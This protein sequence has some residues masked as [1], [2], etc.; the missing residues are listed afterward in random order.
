M[1]SKRL[2]LLEAQ[3][4]QKKPSTERR[5]EAPQ[6][7]RLSTAKS[8]AG[9]VNNGRK[10][11]EVV[12]DAVDEGLDGRR[13]NEIVTDAVDERPPSTA[14]LEKLRSSTTKAFA[15]IENDNWANEIVNIAV[16]ARINA[17]ALKKQTSSAKKLR[18][19]VGNVRRAKG[20]VAD[21][22]D[23]TLD[24]V[25]LEKQTPPAT[26]SRSAFVNDRRAEEVVTDAV[27]EGLNHGSAK[28]IGTDAVDE[29]F[30]TVA[31]ERSSATK[32]RIPF[33]NV[34][35]ANEIMTDTVNERVNVVALGEQR[36]SATKPFSASVIGSRRAKEI[37]TDAVVGERLNAVA[38]VKQRSLTIKPRITFVIRQKAKDIVT[39]TVDARLNPDALEKQMSSTTRP[40]SAFADRNKASEIV[41]DPEDERLDAVA[42]MLDARS[43]DGDED[44]DT[45]DTR[46]GIRDEDAD[47]LDTGGDT[48]DEDVNILD[49]DGNGE[50][51]FAEDQSLPFNCYED[52]DILDADENGDKQI[53]DDQSLPT[54]SEHVVGSSRKR[55]REMAGGQVTDLY[56]ES[57][58]ANCTDN[59]QGSISVPSDGRI[60]IKFD[61][62]GRPCDVGSVAFATYIGKIV[63]A[64]CRPAI[65]S[66]TK[67][68]NSVKDTIW[69]N[70]I[71]MY[72]VPEIYK[73]NVLSRAGMS[74]RN[75]KHNLRLEL[76][77]QKTIAERKKNIPWRLITKREDW[78]SFVDFC[79]TDEDRKRRAAG[80]KACEAVELIQKCGRTGIY[81]KIYEMEKESPTGE[82]NRAAIFV[83]THVSKTVNDPKM[84]LVKELVE[85]NPDGQ[86][87]IDH[88]AVA[89]VYGRD[90]S[91]IKGM[92]AG[93]SRTKIRTL[94]ASSE[95]LRRVQQEN[96]SLQSDI[97]VLRTQLGVHTPNHTSMA[98]SS[99]ILRRVQ[100]ENTSLQ[101]DIHVLRTQL[102]VHTPNHTSIQSNQSVAHTQN[103]TSALSNQSAPYSQNRT[104][105]PSNQY[106]PQTQIRT[107][108]PSNQSAPHTQNRMSTPSNQFASQALEASNSP[109]RSRFV[110]DVFNLPTR[111]CLAPPASN[112]P[113]M[114][115]FIK[116]FK[117]KTIALGSINTADP[118]MENVYSLVFEE[119]FD[120]DAELFDEDGKLGDVMIG[121]V[122]NWPKACVEFNL[123]AN[124]CFIRN[125]KRRTI[126]FGSINTAESPMEHVYSVIVKEIFDRD[127]ELFDEDGKLGDIMIGGL[128]NWPKACVQPC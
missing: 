123:P 35:R 20:I 14:A 16:D 125:F 57:N 37:G 95:I 65:V 46:S 22:V 8:R 47:M 111:S 42:D 102:G 30:D 74:W 82:V 32:A 103:R 126:A 15:A 60:P 114:S 36:S 31:I 107:P 7:K 63:R 113:A 127:A 117:G 69:K 71:H 5:R 40:F 59:G 50:M 124:S 100:Q 75:W 62:Y 92:G 43:D 73:P 76:D 29:R 109:A 66:W 98:A 1:R 19:A 39:D 94:A 44:T 83:D 13:A 90:S 93:V 88:D 24:A 67:V 18:S 101:S 10:A 91:F 52:A 55:N 21:A 78:E 34:S 11:K 80:K 53:L 97:H 12:T 87:D 72:A 2:E 96:K 89:L 70:V 56:R 122:I 112:L 41:T 4:K 77:E 85:A 27:D 84:K 28:E 86:K 38:L 23:E 104:S 3:Q 61:K 49:A 68:P 128:I 26:K 79:N 81:R 115:C 9:S 106:A 116:N 17:V 58:S 120:R 54:N 118:P 51:Q 99:E 110:P 105:T 121:G 25:S 64:C 108:T 33:V 48:R 119:V 6:N 45:L